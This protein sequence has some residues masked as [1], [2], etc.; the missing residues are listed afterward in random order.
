MAEGWRKR[1]PD[2]PRR[3]RSAVLRQTL[4][5]DEL[6]ELLVRGVGDDPHEKP[7]TRAGRRRAHAADSMS[8]V[9]GRAP[10]SG[11]EQ[12]RLLGAPAI[13]RSGASSRPAAARAPESHASARRAIGADRTRPPRSPTT[14][15]DH[16]DPTGGRARARPRSPRRSS[17]RARSR[18]EEVRRARGARRVRPRPSRRAGPCAAAERPLPEPAAPP[19][20]SGLAPDRR[21]AAD[22]TP[23]AAP[24]GSRRDLGPPRR[25]RR[26]RSAADIAVRAEPVDGARERRPRRDS[27]AGRAREPPARSRRTSGGGTSARLRAE[28]RGARPGHRDEDAVGARRG[29][30]HPVRQ[31]DRRGRQAR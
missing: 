31:P 3:G 15:R 7:G 11:R 5:R 21:R 26:R 19:P 10:P 6:R 4:A 20:A 1:A 23:R 12:A 30:R 2:D 9:A 27:A 28:I 8:T 18:V 13:R 16:D 25:R 24:S 17:A 22:A 14:G 29:E